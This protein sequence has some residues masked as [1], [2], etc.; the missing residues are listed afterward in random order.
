MDTHI[1][2]RPAIENVNM[3]LQSQPF[4]FFF[5]SFFCCC[6]PRAEKRGKKRKERLKRKKGEELIK[7]KSRGGSLIQTT[8]WRGVDNSI[9]KYYVWHLLYRR[10]QI[11]LS[12]ALPLS[13]RLRRARAHTRA[14][15]ADAHIWVCVRS[16]KEHKKPTHRSINSPPPPKNQNKINKRNFN[17]RTQVAYSTTEVSIKMFE[18]FQFNTISNK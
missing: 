9:I 15:T 12:F 16:L 4:F 3:S 7:G 14:C 17:A 2:I 8:F 13:L 11:S 18:M 6:C 10:L 1:Y 5:F